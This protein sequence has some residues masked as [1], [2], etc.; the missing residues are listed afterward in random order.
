MYCNCS[1]CRLAITSSASMDS[2]SFS[3]SLYAADAAYLPCT[4]L[5]CLSFSPIIHFCRPL[6]SSKRASS[7]VSLAICALSTPPT[8]SPP[9]N[10]PKPPD[11]IRDRAASPSRT[12]TLVRRRL[13]SS[14]A[15]MRSARLTPSSVSLISST[16]GELA[17]SSPIIARNPAFSARIFSLSSACCDAII[18]SFSC[19]QNLILS[20]ACTGTLTYVGFMLSLVS[21]GIHLAAYCIAW[22][23]ATVSSALCA[24]P[25]ISSAASLMAAP[26]ADWTPLT[27]EANAR[28]SSDALTRSASVSS[29]SKLARV[30]TESS[31]AR[32]LAA[33]AS[34]SS[35][36][37]PK[38]PNTAGEDVTSNDDAVARD[39]PGPPA[40]RAEWGALAALKAAGRPPRLAFSYLSSSSS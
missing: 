5:I 29:S 28:R 9:K 23:A 25:S 14:T 24:S 18:A 2:C 4:S 16:A 8:P 6:S 21:T 13:I 37:P 27:C 31:L 1:A 30:E 39:D 26:N 38:P 32:T 15:E 36:F 17:S 40:P 7:V 3:C 10:D 22:N 11:D 19:S 34:A 20:T 12:A 35:P 33:S